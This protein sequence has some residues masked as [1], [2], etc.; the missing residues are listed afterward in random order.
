MSDTNLPP[1]PA[2]SRPRLPDS[3]GVPAS[4]EGL[5]TWDYVTERMSRARFFWVATTGAN[6]RPH[7]RP[8]WGVW[9]DDTAYFGGGHDTR[10]A[11]NLAANPAVTLHLESAEEVV[12]FEGTVDRLTEDNADPALLARIDAAYEAKYGTPHGTPVFRVR[13]RVVFGWKEFP[14]TPT[15]WRFE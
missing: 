9:L 2:A 1:V 4:G 12:I 7:T 15:A 5:L 8:V 10:W 13:P 11:R 6:N 3:Y 14:T